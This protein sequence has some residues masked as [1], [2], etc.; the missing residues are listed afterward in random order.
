MFEI[1]AVSSQ[2]TFCVSHCQPKIKQYEI[3]VHIYEQKNYLVHHVSNV[4]FMS[5]SAEYPYDS[6]NEERALLIISMS[7]MTCIK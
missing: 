7:N 2:Y 6:L 3:F 5:T 4:H 1:Q